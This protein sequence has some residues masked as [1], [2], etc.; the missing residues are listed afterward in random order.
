[1]I[2]G[3]GNRPL[4][5]RSDLIRRLKERHISHALRADEGR[6]AI[7]HDAARGPGAL[8]H[9]RCYTDLFDPESEFDAGHIRLARE[10]RS[11]RRG[12]GKPQTC[13]AKMC[14]GDTPTISPA[15]FSSR[16]QPADPAGAGD[17]P[18]D[19]EQRRDPAA[20]SRSLNAMAWSWSDPMPAKMAEAGEA[21]VA[22]WRSH[23]K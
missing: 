13:M 11:D 5:K 22:G 10:L 12:A 7:C 8:S 3:G 23:W 16:N 20:T 19:V 9:E 21:G 2:I 15:R 1:L 6:A 4:I 14:A 18:A 17:E